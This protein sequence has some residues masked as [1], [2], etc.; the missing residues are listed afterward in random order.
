MSS[1]N[2]AMISDNVNA[3][4]LAHMETDGLPDPLTDPSA[5]KVFSSHC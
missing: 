1:D 5:E 4:G 2:T 3:D